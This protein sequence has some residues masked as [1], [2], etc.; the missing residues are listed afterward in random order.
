MVRVLIGD[1]FKS[2]AQTLVNTVNCVGVMG[3][4]IALEFKKR[5]PAMYKDY[6]ERCKRGEVRLGF[7][8]LYSYL[9][10]PWILNFPTKQDWRSVSR[11]S[12]IEDGFRYLEQHYKDWEITS[13]AVPPLGTGLGKLEWKVV[14]RTLYK[15][16]KRLDIPVDLYAPRGTPEEQLTER[17]LGEPLPI[18]LHETWNSKHSRIEPGFIAILEVL[19]RLEENPYHPPVGRTGFQKLAYFA[20]MVGLETGLVYRRGSFGPFADELKA[21][22]TQLVNNKLLREE[23]VGG[24]FRAIVDASF[25]NAEISYREYL[26]RSHEPIDR[27]TDLFSRLNTHDAEL[28]ATVHFAW[29]AIKNRKIGKCSE[30]DVL[31]E[32]MEWKKR[33]RPPLERVEVA[34]TIRTLAVRGWLD[35]KPSVDMPKEI[36]EELEV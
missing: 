7:P 11:L 26:S 22:L 24:L 13:I 14:G 33:H 3:K 27:L 20:T 18:M 5:F 32:V 36:E 12:D 10:P 29:L 15:H 21:K 28:A 30:A 35:V 2:R 6:I 19:R 34:K 23:K 25:E 9:E 8:Y 31:R 17:F 1:I 16:L 4:G